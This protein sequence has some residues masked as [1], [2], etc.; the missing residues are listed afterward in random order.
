MDRSRQAVVQTSDIWSQTAETVFAPEKEPAAPAISPQ[1]HGGILRRVRHESSTP[2]TQTRLRIAG[3]VADQAARRVGTVAILTAVTTLGAAILQH[4]LQPEMVEAQRTLLYRFSALSLIL[5]AAGIGYLQRAESLNAHRLLD[6]GLV[7]EIFGAVVIGLLENTVPWRE[8]AV[9]GSTPVAAWI[10]I[11]VVLIPNQ[12]RKSIAAAV[13]SA[14]T[15]P[16][17]HLAAARILGYPPLTW[18]HLTSYALSAI[19]VAAWTPFISTRLYRMQEDLSRTQDLGSYH[20]EK[21]IGRG[22]MGEV[23][24]ARHHL[25]RRD[26]AVKLVLPSL[27]ERMAGSDRRELQRRFELEAQSIASLR[28]AHTVSIYDFGLA[29]NGS[30]YYVMEFLDGIDAEM[31]VKQHGPQPAGRVVSFLVQACE[32]LEEAHDAGLVHRDVKPKNLFICRVGKR[33]D[34]LKLLDFGLVN[35]PSQTL[36]TGGAGATGTPAFMAPE[37]VR[38]DAVDGRAD[39]YALG[40]TAYFL[41]TGETVF[42]KPNVLAA[43]PAHVTEHPRQLSSRSELAIPNSLDQV[44]M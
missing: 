18:D 1:P 21:L 40:C 9:R 19:F 30:L 23:W 11:W 31:L 29:E 37:Q 34:F 41:L 14:A 12:P 7:L 8:D 36:N 3:D 10:A 25:L 32:S 27:L 35:D 44:V 26:A 42:N 39:I 16:C 5:V 15:V 13:I 6:L 38:G 43:A 22:G 4:A 24:L 17:T 28:S 20:L 33:T 2:G